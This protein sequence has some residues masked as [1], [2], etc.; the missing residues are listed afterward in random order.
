VELS[1]SRHHN[2][3]KKQRFFSNVVN[4]GK[5][6]AILYVWMMLGVITLIAHF[7][8]GCLIGCCSIWSAVIC[9]LCVCASDVFQKI[10]IWF[11]LVLRNTK[12]VWLVVL[13]IELHYKH[14]MKMHWMQPTLTN[15]D[16]FIQSITRSWTF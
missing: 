11:V 5:E 7:C 1:A 2:I 9:R 6:T 10:N 14:H 4:C 12:F 13:R 15:T 3:Y 8:S 16:A